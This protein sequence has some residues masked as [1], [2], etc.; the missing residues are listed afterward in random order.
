MESFEPFE[1]SRFHFAGVAAEDRVPLFTSSDQLCAYDE[2]RPES[3]PEETDAVP[4]QP[5][6]C[7]AAY[8]RASPFG[9]ECL[10]REGS[11][12]NIGRNVVIPVCG[13]AG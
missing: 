4:D 8:R 5:A 9:Q 11:G 2:Q 1:P 7:S 6:S 10:R 13:H 3:Q 12:H